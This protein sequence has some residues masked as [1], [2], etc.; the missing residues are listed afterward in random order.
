MHT[1][2]PKQSRLEIDL[3]QIFQYL[4]EYVHTYVLIVTG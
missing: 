3:C 1:M 4:I 2:D